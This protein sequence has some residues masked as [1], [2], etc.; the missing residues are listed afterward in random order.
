[1]PR[2]SAGRYPPCA[3]HVPRRARP[4]PGPS[5]H[6]SRRARPSRARFPPSPDTLFAS[7]TLRVLRPVPD[8]A[9]APPSLAYKTV[10]SVQTCDPCARNERFCT[11]FSL[12][13]GRDGRPPLKRRRTPASELG[14]HAARKFRFPRKQPMRRFTPQFPYKT[15][16][17]MQERPPSADN[18]RFCTRLIAA[19]YLNAAD[20]RTPPKSLTSRSGV[21]VP[22]KQ[23]APAWCRGLRLGQVRD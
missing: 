10:D 5:S 13:H 6:V 1:M 21:S 7:P 15:V 18:R 9:C 19:R 14:K 16:D 8:A 17:S 22:G 4:L 12:F 3:P 11:R 2:L 23:K 20:R